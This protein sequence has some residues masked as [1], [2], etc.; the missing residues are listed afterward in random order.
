MKRKNRTQSEEQNSLSRRAVKAH[1]QSGL[2]HSTPGLWEQRLSDPGADI[3]GFT[4]RNC[5][6][7][8]AWA[9][10]GTLQRNHCPWCL[11]SLHLDFE[12]GDR[13]ADCGA[14]MEPI[15]V[16]VRR[17]D[18]WCLIHRCLACGALSSNRVASDD[19]ELALLSIAARPLGRPPFPVILKPEASHPP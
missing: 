16:W 19:H 10:G 8:V 1:R 12:P 11:Y 2:E 13:S 14:L 3:D 17:K 7:F 4:C 18:E 15:A 9:G 6:A 5:G